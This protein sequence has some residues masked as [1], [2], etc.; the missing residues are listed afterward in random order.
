MANPAIQLRDPAE[1]Q[2]EHDRLA[3]ILLDE[4][5]QQMVGI[6]AD[7]LAEMDALCCV[8]CWVLGHDHNDQFEQ[9]LYRLDERCRAAGFHLPTEPN[10]PKE[11]RQ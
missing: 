6:T 7:Q 5:V 8:L 2:R 1:I 9:Y 10:A 11:S 4:R 3:G